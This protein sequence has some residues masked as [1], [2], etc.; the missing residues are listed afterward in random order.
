[1]AEI[2]A[3]DT[4]IPNALA[5]L[6]RELDSRTTQL[7]KAQA[8]PLKDYTADYQKLKEVFVAQ[9]THLSFYDQFSVPTRKFISQRGIDAEERCGKQ[10]NKLYA[11]HGITLA[12]LRRDF[13]PKALES[14]SL[15]VDLNILLN[16][17]VPWNDIV[18]DVEAARQARLR[19]R[20]RG[21]RAAL[22]VIAGDVNKVL[23]TLYQNAL[24][25]YAITTGI[26][27]RDFG[28]QA[29]KNAAL[30]CAILKFLEQG[31]SWSEVTS[32]S[33]RERELRKVNTNKASSAD[34]QAVD[35]TKAF[36]LFREEDEEENEENEEQRSDPDEEHETAANE[37]RRTQSGV[38]A[39]TKRSLEQEEQP[40]VDAAPRKPEKAALQTSANTGSK[41]S[42]DKEK[43]LFFDTRHRR[44]RK[45]PKKLSHHI[46]VNTSGPRSRSSSIEHARNATEYPLQDRDSDSD[47]SHLDL[48][49][50]DNISDDEAPPS[51][52]RDLANAIH[53]KNNHDDRENPPHDQDHDLG[54]EIDDGNFTDEL[55]HRDKPGAVLDPNFSCYTAQFGSRQ[56]NAA[57]PSLKPLA[58]KAQPP[59]TEAHSPPRTLLSVAAH[60]IS[61][62]AESEGNSVAKYE[63]SSPCPAK[64][65]RNHLRDAKV[66]LVQMQTRSTSH[67]I[68]DPSIAILPNS[69]SGDGNTLP[70][71]SIRPTI[72]NTASISG[73]PGHMAGPSKSGSSLS[74]TKLRQQGTS[75]NN[76]IEEEQLPNGNNIV[77]A[78][79]RRPLDDLEPGQRLSF[80]TIAAIMHVFCFG[81]PQALFLHSSPSTFDCSAP[82]SIHPNNVKKIQETINNQ[83]VRIVLLPIHHLHMETGVNQSHWTCAIIHLHNGLVQHF[84]SCTRK[85]HEDWA[86]EYLEDITKL[87]LLRHPLIFVEEAAQQQVD[88][89]NCGIFAIMNMIR[90]LIPDTITWDTTSALDSIDPAHW[91]AIFTSMFANDAHGI[92]ANADA[93]AGSSLIS[94]KSEPI[95]R[96]LNFTKGHMVQRRAILTA[97]TVP[98]RNVSMKNEQM[99]SYLKQL[100]AEKAILEESDKLMDMLARGLDLAVAWKMQKE[101]AKR[102][103][104]N[105]A[106]EAENDNIVQR[107]LD[108]LRPHCKAALLLGQ[109]SGVEERD[110]EDVEEHN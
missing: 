24:G 63:P 37:V 70:P 90:A 75:V 84:D 52:S 72:P 23:V 53:T 86:R 104:K 54:F 51:P 11:V 26:I 10:L 88:G 14:R 20:T 95:L 101:A 62:S 85:A 107:M 4:T 93:T 38:N 74:A 108:K 99:P 2:A 110:G 45:K 57:G 3:A 9:C 59:P 34:I 109:E 71:A 69:R 29:S 44:G 102:K 6:I 91:R 40:N 1:M 94:G 81:H 105:D 100:V 46:E 79:N 17:N 22:H 43:E 25:G 12:I 67:E 33:Q 77:L 103:R 58:R 19:I 7:L 61:N 64:L 60:P 73:D 36:H 16:K 32:S 87:L 35:V 82:A 78:D 80:T 98:Q 13:G 89:F 97:F 92:K 18:C 41:R 28:D 15:L 47:W 65:S 96:I 39:S 31:A 68:K 42:H 30:L 106:S 55:L 21:Q 50:N 8:Q 76:P 27:D 56:S 48:K 49:D 5:H 66:T 83:I